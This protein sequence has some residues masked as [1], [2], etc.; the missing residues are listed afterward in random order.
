MNEPIILG[1]G[2][3]GLSA[4]YNSKGTLYER[5]SEVGGHASSHEIDGYIF[6]EGIHVLHTSNEYVLNLMQEIDA[7]MEVRNRDAWIYSH[8]SMTRYPF[9]ANTYG[10]PINIVK[11]CLIGFIEN[12]FNDRDKIQNYRDWIYFMFGKGIAEHFMIP[13]SK[14]FWGINPEMLTTDWVNV[15]HPKPSLDEVITGA[16]TDQKKRFGINASYRYP[17]I[18]GFSNIAKSM[19]KKCVD[20]IKC[21]MEVT[22]IDSINKIVHFN[23]NKK[24]EYKSQ[25][26]S[27][28]PLPDL[29]P[30]IA[31]CPKE[32][33]RESKKLKTN[34]IFVVNLGVDRQNISDKNWIYYLD[35]EFSFFRISFPFN[36]SNSVA[37]KNKSSISAEIDYGNNN[38]L[39][40]EK[41]NLAD[42]VIKDLIKA[43]ILKKTDKLEVINTFDIKKAYVIFDK[44]RKPVIKKIHKYLK[45]QDIIPCGRYGDWAYHWSD[46]A[47]LSGKKSI[48]KYNSHN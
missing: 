10:L 16:I 8:K 36:Q 15:R 41:D 3:A 42:L 34:S 27:T 22:N 38:R 32:L 13:Y 5:Q 37:P 25:I 46:E 2:L 28:I 7:K 14:K 29:L 4:C 17:K 33:I 45:S 43:K 12:K 35:K 48:E 44:N 11:D 9:Q 24:V 26:I 47:I 21:G 1:G 30:L 19:S 6:D 18:K 40:A 23:N 20:R 31:N 39:P